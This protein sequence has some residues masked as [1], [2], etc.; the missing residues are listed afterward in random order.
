MSAYK[1]KTP[2]KKRQELYNRVT[3][4]QP[5]RIPIICERAAQSKDIPVMADTKFL[6][7]KEC[8]VG[9]FMSNIRPKIKLEPHQAI[10]LFVG[11][12]N[13][14]PSVSMTMEE[15]HQT[16]KSDDGLLYLQYSG[17]NTFG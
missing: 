6:A 11:E 9:E 3:K 10:F 4:T 16:Y 1:A 8:T 12:Q 14:L 5:G 15:L 7:P 2:F 17:E 13:V